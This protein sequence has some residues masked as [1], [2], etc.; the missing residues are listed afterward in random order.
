MQWYKINVVKNNIKISILFNLIKLILKLFIEYLNVQW[1]Y[2]TEV[3]NIF[4]N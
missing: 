4:E 2:C 3:E 1:V